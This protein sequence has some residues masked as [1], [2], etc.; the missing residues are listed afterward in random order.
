MIPVA[1]SHL[2]TLSMLMLYRGGDTGQNVSSTNWSS[3]IFAKVD[4]TKFLCTLDGR[5][6]GWW[7][8]VVTGPLMCV[9]CILCILCPWLLHGLVTGAESPPTLSPC[10]R[11]HL[12]ILYTYCEM[13]FL[14]SWHWPFC[15]LG[16]YYSCILKL[17]ILWFNLSLYAHFKLWTPEQRYEIS[18][19]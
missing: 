5:I 3:F 1:I 16:R 15:P 14:I 6:S 17:N 18:G 12:N 4:V 2:F 19:T 11:S 7:G 13:I 10:H 8:G 9:P